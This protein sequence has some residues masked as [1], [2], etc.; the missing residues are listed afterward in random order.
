MTDNTFLCDSDS[1][2]HPITLNLCDSG[3]P[4]Q[5]SSYVEHSGISPLLKSLEDASWCD[6]CMQIVSSPGMF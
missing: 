2:L 1:H 5:K 3:Q 4:V 6:G